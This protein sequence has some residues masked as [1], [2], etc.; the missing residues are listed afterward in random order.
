MTKA[1]G[2]KRFIT[3]A[4]YKNLKGVLSDYSIS[5]VKNLTGRSAATLKF[6]RES[7]SFEQYKADG[8]ARYMASEK[9]LKHHQLAPA[10][11][12]VAVEELLPEPEV[13]IAEQLANIENKINALNAAV[14]ALLKTQDIKY[15]I[16]RRK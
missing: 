15:S 9:Y 11:K 6:I 4:E 8:L 16:W 2:S 3:E 7:N 12:Q 5:A 14:N 1:K 13:S 10:P